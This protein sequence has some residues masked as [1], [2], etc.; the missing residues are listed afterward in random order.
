[1]STYQ[2]ISTISIIIPTC[3]EAANISR[4]LPEILAT[5]GVEVLVVDGGSTDNTGVIANAL[6]AKVLSASAGKAFQM[7]VGARAAASDIL[8]FL[9]ADTLLPP[10]FTEQ[11]QHTLCQP[12]IAA[13]AFLLAIDGKGFGLRMIEW[14]ANLR[15]RMLQLPYGDQGIF[16]RADM[17]SS[18]EGF[19]VIP[20]MEDFELVRKLKRKG[21][22]KILPLPATTSSRRWK[23]FGLLRTTVI[24]Q[25]I[26]IGYLLGVSPST[27]A[28]W[29]RRRAKN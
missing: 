3:N 23:E 25:A 14:L 18:V 24:N 5:P 27:L 11:V 29:Y 9:H 22:I 1:M 13:G 8:L 2:K 7:N 16:L 12:D 10:D 6:G 21:R 20:I 4:L 17:F 15:A 26:I 28:K 19:P